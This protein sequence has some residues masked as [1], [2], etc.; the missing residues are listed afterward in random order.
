MD[1][2]DQLNQC[3][4][5]VQAFYPSISSSLASMLQSLRMRHMYL[6]DNLSKPYAE[7]LVV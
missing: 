2:V 6:I 3:L 5:L 4:I 1:D 7:S